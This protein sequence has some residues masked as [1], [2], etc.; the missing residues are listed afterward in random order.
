VKGQIFEAVQVKEHQF[1]N[2][3]NQ[4]QAAKMGRRRRQSMGTAVVEFFEGEAGS[5]KPAGP[6]SALS[7]DLLSLSRSRSRSRSRTHSKSPAAGRLSASMRQDRHGHRVEGSHDR[8]SNRMYGVGFGCDITYKTRDRGLRR[9]KARTGTIRSVSTRIGCAA[10]QAEATTS[11]NFYTIAEGR[12]EPSKA[13]V[14]SS[15]V[16][17]MTKQRYAEQS[18]YKDTQITSTLHHTLNESGAS[19]L[20]SPKLHQKRGVDLEEVKGYAQQST[21]PA[22]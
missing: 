1:Q 16:H 19:P 13:L 11:G 5:E 6:T 10:R 3:N 15:P 20:K 18:F 22:V 7:N 2:D 9:F 4:L 14:A 21:I 12:E 8:D 17:N